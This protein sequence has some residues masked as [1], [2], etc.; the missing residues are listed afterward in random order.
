MALVGHR[1]R[2]HVLGCEAKVPGVQ[3]EIEAVHR[4]GFHAEA[5]RWHRQCF[6]NLDQRVLRMIDR[7]QKRLL[8]PGR[9]PRKDHQG[10]HCWSNRPHLQLDTN[11][12]GPAGRIIPRTVAAPD[13]PVGEGSMDHSGPR[14]SLSAGSYLTRLICLMYNCST[15]FDPHSLRAG[16]RQ[17]AIHDTRY[18]RR[19][20]EFGTPLGDHRSL[21]SRVRWVY[22]HPAVPT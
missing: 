4:I 18:T 21:S 13:G 17:G 1:R 9:E 22:R 10:H 5:H 11:Q 15:E 20:H 6:V 19:K 16:I 2:V 8:R 7:R 3:E 14:L 12:A